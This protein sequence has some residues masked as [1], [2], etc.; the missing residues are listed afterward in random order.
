M[1]AYSLCIQ[2]F[3]DEPN[4]ADDTILLSILQSATPESGKFAIPVGGVGTAAEQEAFERGLDEDLYRLIDISPI[5]IQPNTMFRI[6]KLTDKGFGR[7]AQLV[8]NLN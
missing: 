4:A 1:A 7:L 2:T 8:G 6:F 5:S 3:G